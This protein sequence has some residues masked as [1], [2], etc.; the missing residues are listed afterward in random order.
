[1][2]CRCR[3]CRPK[4]ASVRR[5]IRTIAGSF[6][7]SRLSIRSASKKTLSLNLAARK[8]ERT[9][10]DSQRLA[11]ENSRRASKGQPAFKTIEE[12]EKDFSDSKDKSKKDK[13]NEDGAKDSKDEFDIVL[14]QASEI[15]G[16]MIT[17]GHQL[18]STRSPPQ[19]V[20]ADVRVPAATPKPN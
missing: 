20:K 10:L 19:T 9:Q 14:T 5:K 16:D 7:A 2:T 3:R 12:L 17:G 6:R 8:E 13:D 1:M 18:T 11:R 15:M 4:K